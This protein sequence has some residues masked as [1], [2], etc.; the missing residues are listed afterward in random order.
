[1]KK[2]LFIQIT[3]QEK[4]ALHLSFIIIFSLILCSFPVSLLWRQY[5]SV[6][7]VTPAYQTFIMEQKIFFFG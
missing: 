7:T 3:V 4:C 5:N 6:G 2:Q 1:M